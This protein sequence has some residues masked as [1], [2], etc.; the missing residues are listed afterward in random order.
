MTIASTAR[1][2][3]SPSEEAA[4]L[5]KLMFLSGHD[6]VHFGTVRDG[7]DNWGAP[8]NHF[9]CGDRTYYWATLENHS[10][11]ELDRTLAAVQAFGYIGAAAMSLVKKHGA[12]AEAEAVKL[13]W[14]KA[15]SHRAMFDAITF[16]RQTGTPAFTVIDVAIVRDPG[17]M[18]ICPT[19]PCC[20][21]DE[22]QVL[23][24]LCRLA[25]ED[26]VY[27]SAHDDCAQP[28]VLC[29][30]TFAYACADGEDIEPSQLNL[31]VEVYDKWGYDG[32]CGLI[33]LR[34][35]YDVLPRYINE[36]YLAAKAFLQD[37]VARVES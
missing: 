34:R 23:R 19:D 20:N 14:L 18:H 22:L 36:K 29:S 9:V 26:L 33:A 4:F 16:C 2:F 32:V 6:V 10:E 27:F 11:D 3:G 31:L 7:R 37:K 15:D 35:G 28:F 17:K 8:C 1:D 30:D 12:Q 13:P 25:A 21:D 5:R 24:S